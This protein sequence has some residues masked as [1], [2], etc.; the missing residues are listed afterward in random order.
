MKKNGNLL[1]VCAVIALFMLLT[2]FVNA[3]SFSSGA[4]VSNGLNPIGIFDFLVLIFYVFNYK[5]MEVIYLL[6]V[7]GTYGVLSKTAGYQKL[8]DKSVKAIRGKEWIAM[9]ILTLV[10]GLYA[11]ITNDL[12]VIFGVVP[13]IVTVFLRCGTD[14]LTALAAAFG[15]V[16]VGFV[17]QTFGTYGGASLLSALNL[18]VNASILYECLT[19]VVTYVLFNVFAISHMKKIGRV[20]ETKYD[21]FMTPKL[22]ETK[23]KPKNR[24]KVW[25]LVTLFVI[26]LLIG[27]CAFISWDSSFGV[28][29]FKD[30]FTK[31]SEFNIGSRPLFKQLLGSISE[32]GAWTVV[33]MGTVSFLATV[34]IGLVEKVKFNDFVDNFMNGTKKMYKVVF[35]YV[36]INSCY[37]LAYYFPFALTIINS[38]LGK[39]FSF[40]AVFLAGV[41]GLFFSVEYELVGNTLG[42]YLATSYPEKIA[43]AGFALHLGMGF[44]TLLVPTSALLMIVLT[45]LD[46]PYKNW[47]SYIWK[48]ALSLLVALL[49][50]M[51]LMVSL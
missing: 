15:G 31:V 19:F 43:E 47:L 30:A 28:T 29:V 20:N 37:I 4:Y 34:I 32:F 48:F 7:G 2:W 41:L 9:L 8:I 36:L 38:L 6:M 10:I 25:P 46:V 16:F 23:V 3:G 21:M 33:F 17:G 27:I 39:T 24:K 12:L 40:I 44:A 42:S 13:F 51:L 11:S 49:V 45:Y 26:V 35:I 5:A 14:R 18:E 50:I 22:D 1:I